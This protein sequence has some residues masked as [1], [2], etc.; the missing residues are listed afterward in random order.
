MEWP[1]WHFA[2]YSTAKCIANDYS[3][4]NHVSTRLDHC[5]VTV[6]M[7]EDVSYLQLN[8]CKSGA[9]HTSKRTAPQ[10]QPPVCFTR[11]SR[12]LQTTD[13]LHQETVCASLA[14]VFTNVCNQQNSFAFLRDC[15]LFCFFVGSKINTRVF[16]VCQC[17]FFFFDHSFVHVT[18][19]VCITQW[20]WR[21]HSLPF[22]FSY[23]R[24]SFSTFNLYGKGGVV[25]CL[26][27]NR[28][29]L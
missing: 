18:V 25:C 22:V 27:P 23:A 14:H 7:V 8:T 21:L 6:L 9:L 4:G 3:K 11:P 10:W 13:H 20:K 29:K 24:H 15:F 1:K 16:Y 2:R 28:F 12:S 19:N 17:S 5:T 26:Q